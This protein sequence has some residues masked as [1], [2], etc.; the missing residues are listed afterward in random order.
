VSVLSYNQ[1]ATVVVPSASNTQPLSSTLI[2][3]LLG[4]EDFTNI[5]IPK[6]L[7][8]LSGTSVS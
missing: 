8:S 6:S 4:S 3:K 5:L 7:T 1:P 2:E